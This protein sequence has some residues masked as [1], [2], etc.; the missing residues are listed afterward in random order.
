MGMMLSFFFFKTRTHIRDAHV[1]MMH[2]AFFLFIITRASVY[3]SFVFS[4]P[5][6]FFGLSLEER[7]FGK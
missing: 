3:F 7:V 6:L 2:P 1:C 4:Y 5:F